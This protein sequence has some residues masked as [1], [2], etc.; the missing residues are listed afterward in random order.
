M[1]SAIGHALI[2]VGYRV[3]FT[4]TSELVQKLQAARQS[5]QLP[6]ALAKLDRSDLIILDLC[7][8]PRYVESTAWTLGRWDFEAAEL[9]ITG[10]SYCDSSVHLNGRF[11]CWNFSFR[12]IGR[13]M[14]PARKDR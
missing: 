1:G 8:G 2:D 5:L 10:T 12:A 7:A 6:S 14:L 9:H 3:M 11:T 13:F 4:R